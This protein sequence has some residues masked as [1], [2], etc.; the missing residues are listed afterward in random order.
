MSYRTLNTPKMNRPRAS[1][2]KVTRIDPNTGEILSG[3]IQPAYRAPALKRM[4]DRPELAA[5]EVIRLT[6]CPFCRAPSGDRCRRMCG[7]K[8]RN[9]YLPIDRVHEDRR[10]ASEERRNS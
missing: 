2:V 1:K 9:R 4:A 5:I 7:G 10:A 3:T 8:S 6:R